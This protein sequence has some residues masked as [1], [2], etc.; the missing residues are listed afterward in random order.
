MVFSI[1]SK[2][3]DLVDRSLL[4]RYIAGIV[5]SRATRSLD[6]SLARRLNTQYSMGML[7]Y[8]LF[9]SVMLVCGTVA[10]Q[11]QNGIHFDGVDDYVQASAPGPIGS[12]SR[13]VEAWVKQDSAFAAQHV[14]VDWGEFATGKRF[15]L[16]LINRIPRIEVEGGGISSPTPLAV[17]TWHHLAATYDNSATTK[18]KL[19]VDGVLVNGGNVTPTVNTS[20][21]NGI[22][23]GRRTDGINLFN[24]TIDEVRVWN[25][26]RSAAQ[27]NAYKDR[28]FCVPPQGLVAYYKC[29][30]GVAGAFNGGVITLND[31][32]ASANA[33]TLYSFTLNGNTSNWVT[34]ATTPADVSSSSS[35]AACGPYTSP[36]GTTYSN[37]GVFQ[38][39]YTSS[40]GCDSTSNI[41]LS[42]APIDTS[43]TVTGVTLAAQL[44]GAQY[45]WLDCNAG[46]AVIPG[47]IGQTYTAFVNGSYAVRLTLP[48]CVDT[49]ACHTVNNV[50]IDEEAASFNATVWPNPTEGLI[51][52]SAADPVGKMPYR[53]L[54]LQGC[55]VRTGRVQGTNTFIDIADRSAG[56]YVLELLQDGI[57]QRV[58]IL[59]Q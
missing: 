57:R 23:I 18:F 6:F 11:A 33:G 46:Y 37:G 44:S 4:G 7:K 30:Q 32:S 40:T 8:K 29:D 14:V 31:A 27:I 1:R 19:Y 26:V 5:L 38:E 10:L 35:I 55:V 45:Q 15:C 41:T 25:V 48:D 47:A 52:L 53:I 17:G 9:G 42:I 24:G 20:S 2:V 22:L 39:V 51:T 3:M 12:A 56:V 58:R 36:G 13:T 43:V 59:K 54:D 34:G 49:S 21:L 50:G 16:N 28:S